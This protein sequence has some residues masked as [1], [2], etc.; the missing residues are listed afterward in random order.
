MMRSA[1]GFFLGSEFDD[2]LC[3]PIGEDRNGMR[4]SVLSA[5]ARLDLDP[6]HEAAKLAH[7]PGET[8]TQRLASLLAALPDRPS[9]HLNPAMIAARL[10]TLLPR[11]SGPNPPSNASVPRVDAVTKSRVVFF[12]IIMAVMLSAQLIMANRHSPVQTDNA[13]AQASSTVSPGVPPPSSDQ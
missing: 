9:S 10:I 3:A 6:W 1:S 5:L 7:L 2:F 11:R 8:A 4:L 13:R 12:V